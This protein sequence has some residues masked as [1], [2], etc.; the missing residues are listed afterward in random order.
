MGVG[1]KTPTQQKRGL[2]S[3]GVRRIS[4]RERQIENPRG[5]KSIICFSNGKNIYLNDFHC[6]FEY[7]LI[8]Q[9]KSDRRKS[10][11]RGSEDPNKNRG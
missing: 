11:R 8:D 9:R 10:D 2:G 5:G 4:D 3:M 7:L 6:V 1:A